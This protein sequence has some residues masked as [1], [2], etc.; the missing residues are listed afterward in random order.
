MV[1]EEAT[2][3]EV[4]PA[5]LGDRWVDIA[6]GLAFAVFGVALVVIGELTLREDIQGDLLGPTAFPRLLGT[7]LCAGGLYVAIRAWRLP[8]R[9]V[10]AALETEGDEDEPDIPAS[11]IR[12]FSVM[13][14]TLLYGLL[15]TPLGYLVAT[16]VFVAAGLYVLSVRSKVLLVAVPLLLTA[17]CYYVFAEVLHVPLPSG[18]LTEPLRALG[19]SR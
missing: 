7:C 5:R 2:T 8:A 16:P 11:T 6:G 15:L 18:V 10:A 3:S 4:E 14:L 12:A 13:A 1:R 17:L 9:Q 19:W